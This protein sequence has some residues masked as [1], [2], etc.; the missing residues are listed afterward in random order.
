MP[1][2]KIKW[3]VAFDDHVAYLRSM[4]AIKRRQLSK[5]GARLAEFLNAIWP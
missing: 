2:G 3:N 4:D 1:N 5:G